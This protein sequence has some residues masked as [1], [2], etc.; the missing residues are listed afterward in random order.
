MAIVDFKAMKHD[1]ELFDSMADKLIDDTLKKKKRYNTL[2]NNANRLKNEINIILMQIE[3]LCYELS[4]PLNKPIHDFTYQEL[5]NILVDYKIPSVNKEELRVKILRV[6]IRLED[7][8]KLR[9][10]MI[11]LDLYE[12]HLNGMEDD[13]LDEEYIDMD[14]IREERGIS[15]LDELNGALERINFESLLNDSGDFYTF[16]CDGKV[17]LKTIAAQIYGRPSYWI[18]IFNYADNKDYIKKIAVENYKTIDEVIISNELLV[19]LTLKLPKELEF[20]SEEF[21]TSVLKRV[22]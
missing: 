20:Y 7:I 18:Y 12:G 8:N 21:N 10:E 19:G 16:V 3:K 5:E 14:K 22:S 4:I 9:T 1:K 6:R 11:K 17:N 15:P 2:Y 13:T